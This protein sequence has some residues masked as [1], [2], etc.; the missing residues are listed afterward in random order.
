MENN[1]KFNYIFTIE[2][3]N[4]GNFSDFLNN[5]VNKLINNI[6]NVYS[7]SEYIKIEDIQNYFI[8]DNFRFILL[9]DNII[10]W[11]HENFCNGVNIQNKEIREYVKYEIYEG[12]LQN[13]YKIPGYLESS[14]YR[15]IEM[16]SSIYGKDY[17]S[18]HGDGG[19]GILDIISENGSI[20]LIFKGRDTRFGNCDFKMFSHVSKLNLNE[21]I[22]FDFSEYE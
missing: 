11:S 15:G 19:M 8:K 16:Y 1:K 5:I 17:K 2:D 21:K 18:R 9:K 4:S 22:T 14:H 3:I 20:K 7:F 10:F 6:T 12:G 13:L